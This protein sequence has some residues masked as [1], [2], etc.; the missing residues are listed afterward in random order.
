MRGGKPMCGSQQQRGSEAAAR[1]SCSP[2]CQVGFVHHHRDRHATA[3]LAL[4]VCFQSLWGRRAW[5]NG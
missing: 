1:P 5:A 3:P 4:K 2:V